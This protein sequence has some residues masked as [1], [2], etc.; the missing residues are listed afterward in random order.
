MH[1]V[2][3]GF[4]TLLVGTLIGTVG[5]GGILL[6]PALSSFA[7]L[8]THA[9]MGTALFSFIFTGIL[10]TYLYQRRGSIDWKVTIPLC[11][12]ALLFGY[13]GSLA[14]ANT[15]VRSLNLLLAAVIIFAGVYAL[16]PNTSFTNTSDKEATRQ[17]IKLL[18]IGSAV[19][20]GSGLTGV[21]GPV[22]S[23]PIMVAFGFH[24]LTSIAASQ[25]VQITAAL[26]GSIGNF[27]HGFINFSVAWWIT[28]IELI[29]VSIGVYLAHTASS[30]VLKK[31]V[32]IVCIIVG[33]YIFI[34]SW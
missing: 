10:G 29:G 16:K 26:S 1:L 32:S 5:V 23:V 18:F 13:L 19:G 15:S 27:K 7:D 25:V 22:L 8:S 12:G 9:S 11:I 28:L 31:V 34:R 20:F 17:F 14:N 6:I 2:I 33:S 30:S 4:I 3:L 24:P 21:G